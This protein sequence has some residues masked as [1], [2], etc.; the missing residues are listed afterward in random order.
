MTEVKKPKVRPE[1]DP[2]PTER[3]VRVA[4][5]KSDPKT[6]IDKAV[7]APEKMIEVELMRK[8]AFGGQPQEIKATVPAG[9]VME[10]PASEA[11]ALLK[12]GYAR[13]TDRTFE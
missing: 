5:A 12:K 8:Y 9:T 13:A 3:E 7:P 6:A 1:A 2:A 10:L 11:V 4:A